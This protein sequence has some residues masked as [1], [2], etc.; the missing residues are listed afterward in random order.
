[1]M[2]PPNWEVLSNLMTQFPAEP[3]IGY[4]FFQAQTNNPA[5]AAR[6]ASKLA[7]VISGQD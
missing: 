4:L 5:A 2:T 3:R 1:M 7:R 6:T